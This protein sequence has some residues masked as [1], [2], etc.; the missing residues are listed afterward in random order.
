MRE[1]VLSRKRISD[2]AKQSGA[3]ICVDPETLEV[4]L[5]VRDE[6]GSLPLCCDMFPACMAFED[7]DV[8]SGTFR[9]MLEGGD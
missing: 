9:N 4:I 6:T 5:D 3:F 2:H 1:I 8:A 7:D